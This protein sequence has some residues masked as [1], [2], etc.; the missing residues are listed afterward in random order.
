MIYR[1]I[2][3]LEFFLGLNN[4]YYDAVETLKDSLFNEGF[5]EVFSLSHPAGDIPGADVE[6]S[7][8]HLRSQRWVHVKVVLWA[9]SASFNERGPSG[10]L[11]KVM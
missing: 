10:L 4:T 3:Q 1:K 7:P 11:E 6:V 9:A 8:L 2:I 5:V